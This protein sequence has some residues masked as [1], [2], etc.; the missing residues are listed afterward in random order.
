[1]IKKKLVRKVLDMLKKIP[2][3]QYEKFWKEY[4]TNIKLGVIEDPSNRTRLAKLLQ[5]HSSSGDKLTS[6]SEYVKR[7]K[8]KQERIYYIAGANK[9]EVAKSPFVERWVAWVFFFFMCL[10]FFAFSPL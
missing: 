5:F 2:Q 8:P 6:L 3:E 4:S 10:V 7:M 1:M 9:Q